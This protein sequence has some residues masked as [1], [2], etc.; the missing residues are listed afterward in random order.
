MKILEAYNILK[1]LE[2]Q[3]LS[4]LTSGN[5]GHWGQELERFLGMS[6]NSKQLDFED[7]EL[8]TVTLK[9][10]GVIKE[11]LKIA[12]VWDKQYLEKKLETLLVVVRDT[13]NKI[14]SVQLVKPLLHPIYRKY[15]N[16]E[17]DVIMNI[18]LDAISQKNTAVWV[19]KT[20]DTGNKSINS[21]AFYLSAQFVSYIL[22]FKHNSRKSMSKLIFKE[23]AEYEQTK[24]RTAS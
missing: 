19:A 11:D 12:K 23:L 22:G 17:Y 24:T 10:N 8:K 2:G 13:S 20:N 4:I 9:A 5:K 3:Y 16:I 7:G 21:R 6:L 15:F 18:G 14:I 1:N